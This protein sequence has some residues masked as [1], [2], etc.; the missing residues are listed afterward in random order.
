MNTITL[1]LKETFKTS[2]SM[3]IILSK[4]KYLIAQN[5]PSDPVQCLQ[6]Q[7]PLHGIK[8]QCFEELLNLRIPIYLEKNRLADFF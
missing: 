6:N 8:R 5:L 3:D 1:T 7:K 2:F 4:Y